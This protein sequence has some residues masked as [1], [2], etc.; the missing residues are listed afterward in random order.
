MNYDL[1]G[2]VAEFVYSPDRLSAQHLQRFSWL[3]WKGLEFWL[4]TSGLA[5]HFIHTVDHLQA[6]DVLPRALARRLQQNLCDNRARTDAQFQEF[7]RL[8]DRFRA[9]GLPYV[10]HKGYSSIPDFCHDPALRVQ[11]DFDFYIDHADAASFDRVMHDL[12]YQVATTNYREVRYS[13]HP[14]EYGRRRDIYKPTVCHCVELHFDGR[15]E[16]VAAQYWPDHTIKRRRM[17][18]LY[19]ATFPVLTEVE[20][21]VDH[22]E[23]IFRHAA[24]G[25]IRS[26]WLLEWLTVVRTRRTNRPLWLAVRARAIENPK[27]ATAFAFATEMAAAEFGTPAPVGLAW[28]TTALPVRLRRWIACY[29]RRFAL[30]AHPGSKLQL[31]AAQEF[32]LDDGGK[33]RVLLPRHKPNR[34]FFTSSKSRQVRIKAAVMQSWFLAKR[35]V[36]HSTETLR[37]WRELRRWQQFQ[38]RWAES[39]HR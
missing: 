39:L 28:T 2:T 1:A 29:G 11:F 26:S 4:D 18:H 38:S 24:E 12:G 22:A 3:D 31:L 17:Q 7:C 14:G 19:G 35:V 15:Q 33:S 21:M 8:N 34:V 23:H 27:I 37:Y 5:L 36:F 6:L 16:G 9:T 20:Q 25:W 13:T 30:T 32:G 10:V